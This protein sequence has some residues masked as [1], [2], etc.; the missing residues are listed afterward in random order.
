MTPN[1]QTSSSFQWGFIKVVELW[2][3]EQMQAPVGS[4]V[5]KCLL[6]GDATFELTPLFV[7]RSQ[8]ELTTL[9]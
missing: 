7:N 4:R 3:K 1:N 8:E 9:S 6:W 2:G 5:R